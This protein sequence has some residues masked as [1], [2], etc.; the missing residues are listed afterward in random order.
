MSGPLKEG[1]TIQFKRQEY[2]ATKSIRCSNC[3]LHD[4]CMASIAGDINCTGVIFLTP[5]NYII[6]RLKKS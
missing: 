3:A 1:D 5:L 6:Q 2:V 4:E